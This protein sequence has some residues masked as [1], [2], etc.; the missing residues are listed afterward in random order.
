MLQECAGVAGNG[1]TKDSLSYLEPVLQ[2]L[3]LDWT[4]ELTVATHGNPPPSSSRQWLAWSGAAEEQR[5]GLSMPTYQV[6]NTKLLCATPGD[7][8]LFPSSFTTR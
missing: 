3:C 1:K 2:L 5:R 7:L 6:C 4:I 8:D